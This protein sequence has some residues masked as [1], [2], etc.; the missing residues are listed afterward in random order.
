[1]PLERLGLHGQS[2]QLDAACFQVRA[3]LLHHALHLDFHE[4]L[5]SSSVAES[6]SACMTFC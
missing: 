4:R 3:R 5:R 1:V 6:M 2:F